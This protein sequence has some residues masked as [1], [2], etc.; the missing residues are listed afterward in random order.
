MKGPSVR[1]KRPCRVCRKWFM[2]DPRLKD[3]QRTCA[4]SQCKREWHRRRCAQ[5]NKDNPEYF[6]ANYLQKKL[7]AASSDT[8]GPKAL[9]ARLRSALPWEQV[10]DVIG[11]KQLVILE[12]FG[13][14]LLRRFQEVIRTQLAG[15]VNKLS[16]QPSCMCSRRDRH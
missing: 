14:L 1:K 2:P 4:A 10:Q 16:Q 5:W 15:N 7:D 13:G 3:R 12:Y 9:K 6:R 8:Q 11:V